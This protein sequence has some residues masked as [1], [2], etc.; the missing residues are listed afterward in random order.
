MASLWCSSQAKSPAP[1]LLMSRL[2]P[3][4]VAP[5]QHQ[6]GAMRRQRRGDGAADAAARPGE[7]RPIAFHAGNPRKMSPYRP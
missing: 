3:R 2:M 1:A 6:L 7:Q 4:R 5:D